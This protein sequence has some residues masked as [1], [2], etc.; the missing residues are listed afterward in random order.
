MPIS[1]KRNKHLQ[2]VPTEAVKLVPR[3]NPEL[4]SIHE[5][6]LGKGKSKQSNTGNSTKL[7]A[8]MLAV[9]SFEL[10]TVRTFGGGTHGLFKD[11]Q[12]FP[13][14]QSSVTTNSLRQQIDVWSRAFALSQ[15]IV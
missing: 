11:R 8:Y 4:A 14:T 1:N 10:G 12:V 6:V 13:Q 9:E 5:K 15:G 7:V 2:T 3:Y